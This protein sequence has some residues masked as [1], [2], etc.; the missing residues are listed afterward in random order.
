VLETFTASTFEPLVGETFHMHVEGDPVPVDL[1]LTD[2]T[3]LPMASA[4][5]GRAPFSV[6][7]RG[8]AAIYPQRTYQLEHPRL[9]PFELFLVPIGTDADGVRYE[10]VFT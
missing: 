2:A 3:E 9:G 7:F 4:R 5:P 6:V 1:V 10:A 8:P